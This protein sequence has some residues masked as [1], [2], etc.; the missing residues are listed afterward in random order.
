LKESATSRF[1][2]RFFFS[3]FLKMDPNF[4]TEQKAIEEFNDA[5]LLDF[6]NVLEKEEQNPT[7]IDD[8]SV[9]EKIPE[10]HDPE[11]MDMFMLGRQISQEYNIKRVRMLDIGTLST[12]KD[13]N[14]EV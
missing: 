4:Y 12:L 6:I 5:K 9:K 10:A 8:G 7:K 3:F 13:V 2:F 11:S 1:V 14:D